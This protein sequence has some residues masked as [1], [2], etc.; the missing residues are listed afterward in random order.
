MKEEKQL[1][2]NKI[3]SDKGWSTYLK[4][5][6]LINGRNITK[7]AKIFKRFKVRNIFKRKSGLNKQQKIIKM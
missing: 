2:R 4:Q 7:K 6:E 1:L 5:E 3:I